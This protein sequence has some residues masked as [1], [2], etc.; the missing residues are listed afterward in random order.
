[1]DRLGVGFSVLREINPRLVYCAITGYG[2]DGPLRSRAGHDLNYLARTGVLALSGEADGPPVQ[3][4]AQIADVAGG[5]LMAA[6][7][8]MAALRSGE[9]QFVDISMADGALS[10]LAMPAA[11][12]CCAGGRAAAARRADPRR[13]AAL[14]PAVRVRR[15]L[16]LDGRAGAEVLGRVLHGRRPRGP[17]RAPVRRARAR[18]RTPRSRRCSLSRT[19]AEWEAFNAEHDCCLEPV[20]ELEE[21]LQRRADPRPAGWSPAT[22]SATP[23]KLSETPADYERGGP[24]GPRR[25]HRRGARARPATAR[26]RSRRCARRARRSERRVLRAARRRA[27]PGDRAH[28]RAVGRA[29]PAR[30]AAVGAA[31]RPA[32]ADVAARGHGARAHH[33]RD[34]RRRADHRARGRDERRAAGALGRAARR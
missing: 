30:R 23:V 24:P 16:R 1:M 27:L 13:A 9:G 31:H 21:A 8:I 34:P 10:L 4:A 33:G 15:R 6:F 28:E 11:V 17:D 5:A 18:R 2:Q 20:L 22:C 19:R 14:L 32:R 26:T 12:S 7:G 25:A 29:P 3:A